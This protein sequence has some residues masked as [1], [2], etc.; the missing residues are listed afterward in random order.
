MSNTIEHGS[1][2][3]EQTFNALVANYES[4]RDEHQLRY[5]TFS[6]GVLEL[7]QHPEG[8]FFRIHVGKRTDIEDQFCLILVTLDI[9]GK[10][11]QKVVKDEDFGVKRNPP[12]TQGEGPEYLAIEYGKPCPKQ[13]PQMVETSF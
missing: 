8:A 2:I 13:C 11:L 6:I 9:N 3:D 5:E 4:G 12:T 10:V 1:L 7:L